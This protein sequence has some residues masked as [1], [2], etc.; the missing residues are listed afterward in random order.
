M[1]REEKV[2]IRK[3]FYFVIIITIIVIALLIPF[4]FAITPMEQINQEKK[5]FS[6]DSLTKIPGSTLEMTINLNCIQYE[7]F[8][9]T[10]SN[11]NEIASIDT[12]NIEEN[13]EI[14]TNS[15][16]MMISGN[17]TTM[18]MDEIKL[19]YK[20]P[21]DIEVGTTITFKA[22]I[23]QNSKETEE[24]VQTEENTIDNINSKEEQ[25]VQQEMIEVTI[26]II[27]EDKNTNN[28][29]EKQEE[30]KEEKQELNMNN[31]QGENQDNKQNTSQNSQFTSI[32]TSVSNIKTTTSNMQTETITYN[33]S[34][35]N[36]LQTLKVNGYSLT[37]EFSKESTTYFVKI[38][39]EEISSVEIIA[40]AE[41][42]D[43][44]VCI[45]GNENIKE[46]SKI[47]IS[48]TAE[49]GNVRNY[50]IYIIK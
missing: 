49:N 47:L 19:Y 39:A 20:I 41:D 22:E 21:E 7:D 14:E 40:E 43:A 50:R 18:N 37:K 11:K 48:V 3:K 4:V 2:K 13:I 44:I 12:S 25:S 8:I 32:Q 46:G 9:F 36:Y 42:E 23:K 45:Y 33:G 35:N 5:F 10:L 15:D 34:S 17:K 30:K 26:T 27:E 24:K 28:N 29:N 6:V 1:K 16:S 31:Q 38:G